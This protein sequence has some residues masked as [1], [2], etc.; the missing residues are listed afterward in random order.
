MLSC[1]GQRR[2]AACDTRAMSTV[3]ALGRELQETWLREIP[4]ANALAI[5]VASCTP[6]ELVVRA[7]LAANRN[8]HGTAFAGSL[9]AVCVLTGWGAAWRALKTRSAEGLIVV[10]DGRIKYRRAVTG[11][12]VCVCR[13]DPDLVE[14]RLAG[15]AASGRASLSLVCTIDHDGKRAVTFEGEYV[16]HSKAAPHAAQS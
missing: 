6:E 10:A 11:D 13:P 1:R 12:L 9:F 8:L 16:V 3:D 7:P 14:Q 15:L 4:L 2:E 5:E